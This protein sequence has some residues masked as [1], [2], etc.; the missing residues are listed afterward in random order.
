M[1]EFILKNAKVAGFSVVDNSE[2][3]YE[4]SPEYNFNLTPKLEKFAHLIDAQS[5]QFDINKLVD[6]FICWNLPT[7]FSPDGGITYQQSQT[8]YGNNLPSMPTGTN[9]LTA[10]QAKKM[11]WP[12]AEREIW[13]LLSIVTVVAPAPKA[14]VRKVNTGEM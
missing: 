9:L 11:Y 6:K 13:Q 8:I 5:R 4:P 12:S 2:I 1:M 3:I 10:D 14:L 7:D